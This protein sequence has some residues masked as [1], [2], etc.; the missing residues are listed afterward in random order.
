MINY[1]EENNLHSFVSYKFYQGLSTKIIKQVQHN[2]DQ[3]YIKIKEICVLMKIETINRYSSKK[4][5]GFRVLEE[6]IYKHLQQYLDQNQGYAGNQIMIENF[7]IFFMKYKVEDLNVFRLLSNL[8]SWQYEGV[9]M[10][11]QNYKEMIRMF[12]MSIRCNNFQQDVIKKIEQNYDLI[13]KKMSLINIVHL[14]YSSILVKEVH[15]YQ[16]DKEVI[17]DLIDRVLRYDHLSIDNKIQF[18]RLECILYYKGEEEYQKYKDS[19][20]YIDVHCSSSFQLEVKAVLNIMNIENIQEFKVQDLYSC[21][22]YLPDKKMVLEINGPQHY[23]S[24]QM[25][26]FQREAS[27]LLKSGNLNSQ[28]K[29]RLI[30]LMKLGYD[31]KVM[32]FVI[33]QKQLKSV[34]NKRQYLDNLLNLY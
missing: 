6:Y 11:E 13:K 9:E 32:N 31:V 24:Y 14:L 25:D 33:W 4:Y 34:Q 28:S 8:S 21:D 5:I 1:V 12:T 7:M 18:K 27:N 10:S 17:D 16:I 23:Y 19:N 20:K 15:N 2:I 26:G 22:L 29:M 30:N 3:D